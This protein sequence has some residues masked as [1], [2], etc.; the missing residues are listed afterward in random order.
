M[1]EEA[2]KAMLEMQERV[3]LLHRMIH[4]PQGGSGAEEV[5]GM[6]DQ[7]GVDTAEGRGAL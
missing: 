4:S 7:A 1:V 5:D 6:Q 2:E 3:L